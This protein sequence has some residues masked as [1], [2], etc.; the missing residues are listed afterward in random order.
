VG[1]GSTCVGNPQPAPMRVQ[2]LYLQ[3]RQLPMVS[4]NTYVYSLTDIVHGVA[5]AR[6]WVH[7]GALAAVKWQTGN[8]ELVLDLEPLNRPTLL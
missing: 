1:L 4:P 6:P 2:E 3:V 7:P 8:T 5:G